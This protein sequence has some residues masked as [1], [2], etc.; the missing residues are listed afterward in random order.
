MKVSKVIKIMQE[1]NPDDEIIVAWWE[2]EYFPLGPE[3]K[4]AE[5]WSS[6]IETLE[7]RLDCSY[8]TEAI[9]EALEYNDYFV[10]GVSVLGAC[11]ADS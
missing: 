2:K 9:V 11:S 1:L 6:S 10:E 7:D 5:D 8:M 3:L 4:N